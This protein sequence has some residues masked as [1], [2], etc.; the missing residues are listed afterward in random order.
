MKKLLIL[1]VILVAGYFVVSYFNL[2][3]LGPKKFVDG[4]EIF[5]KTYWNEEFG[6]TVKYPSSW[7]A[8]IANEE[9]L[10]APFDNSDQINY[11]GISFDDRELSD[12]RTTLTTKGIKGQEGIINF[13]GQQA[14]QYTFN[15]KSFENTIEIYIPYQNKIFVLRTQRY[16]HEYVKQILSTF[17][18]IK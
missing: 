16:D 5:W 15:T 7:N 14:F 18:F 9:V 13:A 4:P 2:F 12:I 11:V 10:I 3:G 17:K 1:I 8:E 6:F